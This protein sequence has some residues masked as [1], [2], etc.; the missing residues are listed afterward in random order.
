M[1]EVRTTILRSWWSTV[2]LYVSG[3]NGKLRTLHSKLSFESLRRNCGWHHI[4]TAL[5]AGQAPQ[6]PHEWAHTHTHA[7]G[8]SWG[9]A[10][11]VRTLTL[12]LLSPITDVSG[13][14]CCG[15]MPTSY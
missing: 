4:R 5:Q 14:N 12:W 6:L 10:A 15:A 8:A 7:V 11:G 3:G 9:R 1:L 2:T 13:L